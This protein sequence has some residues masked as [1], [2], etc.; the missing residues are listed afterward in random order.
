M[1]T[2]V[3]LMAAV[4]WLGGCAS[5]IPRGVLEAPEKPVSAE[6]VQQ[7]PEAFAGR[8][9]RWGGEIIEIVNAEKHTDVLVLG[10]ELKKKGEPV[11]D[12]RVDARFIARFPGFV[13]PGVLPEG[14]R[15]TVRG[16]VT[17]VEVRKV[18]DYPYPYPVVEV[19]EYHLWPDPRPVDDYRYYYGPYYGWGPPYYR[20]PWWGY[21]YWW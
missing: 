17:G 1:K 11:V 4:L 14:K 12:G 16:K 9:V 19:G 6:A 21:P 2:V 3:Y 20:Y 5:N 13:E 10:R 15:L 7:H 8:V 18:G